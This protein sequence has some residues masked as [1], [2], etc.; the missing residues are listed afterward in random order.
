[1]GWLPVTGCCLSPTPRTLA[2][3]AVGSSAKHAGPQRPHPLLGTGPRGD[4]RDAA[5]PSPQCEAGDGS[6]APPTRGCGISCHQQTSTES[7]TRTRLR[8][9]MTVKADALRGAPGPRRPSPCRGPPST[10]AGCSPALQSPP[11]GLRANCHGVRQL[12]VL[13]EGRD[14]V[15]AVP[16]A[17]GADHE[18]KWP[19]R[20]K[21]SPCPLRAW[22]GWGGGRFCLHS[23]DTM[24]TSRT[25]LRTMEP[26][27]KDEP[28]VR[29]GDGRR[30][31]TPGA[32]RSVAG[33][34]RAPR[35]GSRLPSPRCH[36]QSSRPE[37]GLRGLGARQST[38]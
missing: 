6:D 1:M 11:S 5:Q 37:T 23:I 4:S 16:C 36:R 13:Q 30:R 29:W 34:D 33:C 27:P 26:A 19:P 17:F 18:Q 12:W 15:A 2:S 25:E 24:K 9:M 21:A 10:P 20:G 35:A 14:E 3:S 38:S 31:T 22:H 7:S 8:E 32:R 28:V